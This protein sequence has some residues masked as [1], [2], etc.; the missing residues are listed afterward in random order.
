M[1]LYG[2]RMRIFISLC[3]KK[4]QKC[5]LR[6]V[7]FK[8]YGYYPYLYPTSFLLGM[9]G[10]NSLKLRREMLTMAYVFKL[11]RG[12]VDNPSMLAKVCLFVPD[13][14]N[15]ARS[16]TLF[17]EPSSRTNL[18][19]WSLLTRAL[20]HINALCSAASDLDI[21]T[22]SPHLFKVWALRYLFMLE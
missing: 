21:F 16:H 14:Y 11:V 18:S 2:I 10:Y 6:F 19:R 3:W 20:R 12:K 22:A 7:Y 17:A 5:F 4:N 8:Q 9:V 13:N 15:R 1:Q